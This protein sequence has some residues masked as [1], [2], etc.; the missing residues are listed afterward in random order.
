MGSRFIMKRWFF[1][2]FV[3]L[4]ACIG[5]QWQLRP[6]GDAGED[7]TIVIERFDQVEMLYLTTG[8]F[9]ALQQMKT[10]YPSETRALIEDVLRLGRVDEPDINTRFLLFFQDSTLQTLMGDVEKQYHEVDDLSEQL[11]KAFFRLQHLL[12]SVEIPRVYTQIG[13]LDQSIVVGD[14]MLGI[15]LDKYLGEDYPA[16]LKYGYTDEQRMMMTRQYIVPDCLGFYLL[17][18]YPMS[19][20][21]SETTDSLA[22]H[23]ARRNYMGR[24]QWV[25]NQVTETPV[26]QREEVQL[27]EDYMKSHR[28]TNIE[29]LLALPVFADYHAER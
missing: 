22:L 23:N 9:A 19:E 11:T 24:I 1:L 14:G 26:F 18:R 7:E 4:I 27:V 10:G 3:C 6:N 29:E 20:D 16:Y 12:P 17:S 2:S 8:D 15:S 28:D 21:Q 5:C 13:S 25:V